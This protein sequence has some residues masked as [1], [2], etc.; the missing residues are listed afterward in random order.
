MSILVKKIRKIE[1]MFGKEEKKI[2]ICEKEIKIEARRSISAAQNITVGTKLL[3]S[4]LSW[5]RPGKGLSPGQEKKIVGKV[6]TK[7][8]KMGQ[9]IKISDLK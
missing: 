3:Y 5:V 1:K 6:T 7:D 4:H 8:L 9:I 2:Q